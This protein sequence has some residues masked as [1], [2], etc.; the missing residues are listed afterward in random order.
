MA[1]GDRKK[2]G[3]WREGGK[4]AALFSGGKEGVGSL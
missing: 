3:I 4:G 2:P 1:P